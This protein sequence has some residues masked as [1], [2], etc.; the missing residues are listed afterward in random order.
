M[1]KRISMAAPWVTG[2]VGVLLATG[3]TGLTAQVIKGCIENPGLGGS[4]STTADLVQCPGPY[5]YR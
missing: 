4:W 3:R 1:G 5:L 2:N